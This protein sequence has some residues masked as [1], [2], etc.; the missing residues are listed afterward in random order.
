MSSIKH[1]ISGNMFKVP[2]GV[3]KKNICVE[4]GELA[5]PGFCPTIEEEVFLEENLP[6]RKCTLHA[7]GHGYYPDRQDGP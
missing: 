5:V 1:R 6:E 3:V 4:S 2:E 7:P